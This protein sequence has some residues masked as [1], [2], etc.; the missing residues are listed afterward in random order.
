MVWD[1]MVWCC[2]VLC[3]VVL[4]CVVLCCLV[5]GWGGVGWN[6]VGWGAH[7]FVRH[8]LEVPEMDGD[9]GFDGGPVY[10]ICGIVDGDGIPAGGRG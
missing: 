4:C 1:C 8:R 10:R 3:C 6:G 2:V 7:H 9:G 5:V